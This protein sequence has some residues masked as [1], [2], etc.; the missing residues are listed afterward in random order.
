[1]HVSV[2]GN[3]NVIDTIYDI[4]YKNVSRK[5]SVENQVAHYWFN[6]DTGSQI[7]WETDGFNRKTGDGLTDWGKVESQ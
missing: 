6:G 2:K 3:A 4:Y 7:H 1:M 5:G